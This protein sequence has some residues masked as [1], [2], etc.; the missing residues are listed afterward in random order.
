MSGDVNSI[1]RVTD[2]WCLLNT[3]EFVINAG[4]RT[5]ERVAGTAATQKRET[6]F[7]QRK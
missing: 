1:E 5:V 4:R 6:L 3:R 7:R 2:S